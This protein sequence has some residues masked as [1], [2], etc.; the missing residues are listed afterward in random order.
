MKK[1]WLSVL[2]VLVTVSVFFIACPTDDTLKGGNTVNKTA[3]TTA[4][5]EA[6]NAR[7]GVEKADS[8]LDVPVGSKFV[9]LEEWNVFDTAITVAKN[10][11]D[12]AAAS[13]SAVDNAVAV[14]NAAKAVFEA[15]KKDGMRASF[16]EGELDSLIARAE[17][18]KRSVD[19]SADGNTTYPTD[20]WVT[21]VEM[22][23]L[24]SA[25]VM[26]EAGG[27][28]AKDRYIALNTALTTFNAAKKPGTKS[29]T[30]IDYVL[31][32]SKYDYKVL[33]SAFTS[34]AVTVD[35]VL[36]EPIWTQSESSQIS[37]F[38]HATNPTDVA[39]GA[40]G[41]IKSVWD[42][43][44]LYIAVEVN[45]A[46][47][48]HWPALDSGEDSGDG[49]FTPVVKNKSNSAIAVQ[50]VMDWT[51]FATPAFNGTFDNV[52]FDIDFWNDKQDKWADDDGIFA[53][54]RSGKLVYSSADGFGD[55]GTYASV[56]ASPDA[57][58]YND[59]VKAYAVSEKT[60][61]YI[62]E[63]ALQIYGAKPSNGTSFGVDVMIADAPADNS[64]ITSRTYWSHSDNDYR[65]SS[66]DGNLDWG[67]IVLGGHNDIAQTDFVKNSWMLTNA[68]RW[69]DKNLP[70][71]AGYPG[72]AASVENNWTSETWTVLSNAMS[73][74][75]SLNATTTDQAG[76]KQAAQNVEA[77]IAAL[78]Q[79]DDPLG[80]TAMTYPVTNSLPDPLVFKTDLTGGTPGATVATAGDWA[81]RAEEIRQLASIYEYGPK[82]GAPS[83]VTVSKITAVPGFGTHWEPAPWYYPNRPPMKV[84]SSPSSYSIDS[85]ITYQGTEDSVPAGRMAV[86]GTTN[87][88][89]N[90]YTPSLADGQKAPVILNFDGNQTEF[91]ANGVGVLSIPSTVTTDDRTNGVWDTRAGTFRTFFPYTAR[92]QRYEMSNE[93]GAAWGAWRAI[94]ALKAGKDI[95]IN[96]VSLNISTPVTTGNNYTLKD[97]ITAES[98]TIT[99]QGW[100]GP[101][102]QIVPVWYQVGQ[103]AGDDVLEVQQGSGTP[104]MLYLQAGSPAP[105]GEGTR[106]LTFTRVEHLNEQGLWVDVTA[107]RFGTNTGTTEA[108]VWEKPL[109]AT[110]T[111]GAEIDTGKTL[112]DYIA[113]G[114]DSNPSQLAVTG[115]SI[116]GKYAFT[117]GLYDERIKVVIPGAAGAS[118]PQTW[119]YNPA[120]TVYSAGNGNSTGGELIGDHIMKNPG[121]STEVFR[122]FLTN[123]N[124]YERLR[125]IDANG[126]FSHGYAQRLP[127]DGHELVASMFP[128]AVIERAVMNDFNDGS[129]QDAIAFQGARLVYRKLVDLGLVANTSGGTEINK[130]GIDNLI[131]FNYH[132][133]AYFGDP[134]GAVSFEQRVN[135]TQ[136]MNW[137]FSG[138]TP[139][140]L[141][142]PT[143]LVG[144]NIDPFFTD[145]LIAGGSNSY[146]R[147]YGGFA[148]MMPW[149]W[150]G[151]Y[152]PSR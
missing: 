54:S 24:E 32:Y 90:L 13:Q 55:E 31:P 85:T 109:T 131:V 52:E 120:A 141:S 98:V 130:A 60:G 137:Y 96:S 22:A 51:T 103:L 21:Q 72:S 74:G 121:R 91:T 16:T 86:A 70:G 49:M 133:W 101:E 147:H 135:E 100:L 43:Y 152:Y 23:A 117:A 45:D 93:M 71:T 3:L 37:N 69:V 6:E 66:H 18:A 84:A 50:Q 36:N 47:P 8:A 2:T 27:G 113:Y 87:I 64:A 123:F 62:V 139:S 150:A 63:I 1:K 10:V 142:A 143:A 99:V 140:Y 136:Y 127:Y 102:I 112:A 19:V 14:L 68:I 114:A 73:A 39:S 116:N 28:E 83:T 40:T 88:T 134:H 42:G 59:R 17:E 67:T 12:D 30:R 148:V 97:R 151:S 33:T 9:T 111:I 132:V 129:E 61:G 125:G 124:Y 4:L 75:R 108:P 105:V 41:T 38:K 92:G 118:G 34:A 11:N 44:T 58:E 95:P 94:D 145:V 81:K 149:A 65:F 110:Q 82:P 46:T 107:N 106:N 89:F 53:I 119:R 48:A 146:E 126:D 115:Y 104:T 122:R 29:G 77:A 128:R 35:G 7:S 79:A 5:T 57:R 56:F 20:S 25:I 80:A 76:I 144:W 138:A 15:A 26:A 78:V